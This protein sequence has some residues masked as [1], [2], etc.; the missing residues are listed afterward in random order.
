VQQHHFVWVRQWL[1]AVSRAGGCTCWAVWVVAMRDV[2]GVSSA[3]EYCS[4][5]AGAF[6]VLIVQQQWLSSLLLQSAQQVYQ[7][8]K[9]L[10]RDMLH[11]HGCRLF[12]WVLLQPSLSENH[13]S[14]S[15]R[16]QHSAC[17]YSLLVWR[18]FARWPDSSMALAEHPTQLS[19]WR[20]ARI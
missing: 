15:S 9:A 7:Q 20:H 12:A 17:I 4:Q 2:C 16:V 19:S 18:R 10:W 11:Q 14:C 13:S 6:C 5:T 3:S 8:V 1:A